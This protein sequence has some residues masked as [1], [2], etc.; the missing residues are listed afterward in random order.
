MQSFLTPS[1]KKENRARC[2]KRAKELR[3]LRLELR[4]EWRELM[5]TLQLVIEELEGKAPKGR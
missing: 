1:R 4:E 5:L 2:R 3:G